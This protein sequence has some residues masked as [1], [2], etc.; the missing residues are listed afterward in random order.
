MALPPADKC[1]AQDALATALAAVAAAA[2]RGPEA[3]AAV[4]KALASAVPSGDHQGATPI[5]DNPIALDG[6]SSA[7]KEEPMYRMIY[8]PYYK[9][10][11]HHV[12][13]HLLDGT[14]KYKSFGTEEAAMDFIHRNE[15]RMVNNPITVAKAIELYVDSRADLKQ[16]SRETIRY[17]LEA[18]ADGFEDVLIQ[19]FPA[20]TAWTRLVAEN[21]VDTLHGIRS[22]AVGFFEWCIRHPYLKKNPFAG[23]EIAGRKKRGKAQLRLD[24]ARSF[25][26]RALVVASGERISKRRGSQQEVAVLG[27]ATALVLGLRNSEVVGCQVRDLDD[28]GATLWIAASKTEAGIRRVEI[29]DVL[30][31]P[32]LKLAENRSGTEPLL[33]GLTKDGMRYWTKALCKKLDLPQVTPQGLR[34]THATASMRPHANPHEVAAALGH[35][36]FAVTARHYAKPAAVAAAKQQAAAEALAPSKNPSKTFGR[37]SKAA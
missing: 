36:S 33:P 4:V 25:L 13:L 5:S 3:L 9:N 26:E 37:G 30:R 34:G 12:H 35:E 1:P 29:P 19:A 15:A 22:A 10:G 2:A 18:L 24:E 8:G 16:T 6:G 32:L 17:R 14:R 23:I 7:S 11:H 20:M 27:A 21:A 31:P 28:G